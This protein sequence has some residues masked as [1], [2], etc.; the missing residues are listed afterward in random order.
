MYLHKMYVQSY[1]YVYIETTTRSPK[2]V[3]LF[4]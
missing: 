1:V 3:G 2:K 4:G